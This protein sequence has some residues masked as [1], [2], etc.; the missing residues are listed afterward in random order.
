MKTSLILFLLLALRGAS[1]AQT[2]LVSSNSPPAQ[3]T[4]IESEAGYF[5][6]TT[7]LMVYLGNV[8]VTSP[9]LHLKC[10][11]LAV[12]IPEKGQ[13]LSHLTA[14]TNVVID[15]MDLAQHDTNHIT[16]NLAVYD[17]RVVN[18]MTNWTVTFTGTPS[19]PPVVINSLGTIASE[20]LVWD[21]AKNKIIFIQYRTVL[22][23]NVTGTNN[24]SPINFLK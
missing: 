1:W 20:P 3:K 14:E 22:P 18:S 21:G 2:S 5:D 13:R 8:R 15:Y 12:N 7:R 9:E 19:N 17:Y 6:N 23:I 24:A 11:R 16:A 4:I 10:E